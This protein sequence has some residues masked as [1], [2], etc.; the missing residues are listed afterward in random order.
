MTADALTPNMA[1]AREAEAARTLG[2]R[3]EHWARMQPAKP[4]VK[5]A[6]PWLTYG[7]TERRTAEFGAGLQSLGVGKGDR[8]AILSATRV[9]VVLAL[10]GIARSG[11]IAVPLNTFLKGEFLRFQIQ[12]SEPKAIVVDAEGAAELAAVVGE[13]KHRPTVILLDAAKDGD[14]TKKPDPAKVPATLAALEVHGFT[15]LHLDRNRFAPPAITERDPFCIMYTSGTTGMPKGCVLSH[16][17]MMIC[18]VPQLADGW[19]EPDDITYSLFPL[20]HLAGVG[21]G[22][23][24]S[25]QC[26]SSIVIE[27]VFSARAFIARVVEEGAT[28]AFGIGAA[29]KAVLAA[30]ASE[31]DRRHR[32]RLAIFPPMDP[33]AQEAFEARFGVNL[34]CSAYGQ[35]EIT[36]I[37]R[38]NN[39]EARL[40]RGSLGRPSSRID[41][42]LVDDND[43]PVARGEV[44]EIVVRP[45][46]PELIF[47]GYWKRPDATV[48][49]LR[50]LWH[51]TGDLARFDERGI[52]Y[53]V[54]RKRDAIRRR[55]ENVSS[56]ELERAI[57]KHPKIAAV[58]VHGVPSPLG[59]QEIKACIVGAEGTIDSAELFDFFK[60]TLPYF[61][62]PRYVEF[63]E[64]LPVNAN[65]RVT[66]QLLRERGIGT[67]VDLEAAGFVISREQRRG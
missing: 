7:E 42:E 32:L 6:S 22:L 13:L 34:N 12:E 28:V 21:T 23:L 18:P 45:R 17:Y 60:R 9:E 1:R 52:L 2:P 37:A 49:V 16:G 15:A 26:G 57:L 5:C 46:Q 24:G 8:V 10:F 38:L 35:T 47:Q 65:G 20:F 62:V 14:S 58:A 40:A 50:N 63:F 48:A 41:L 3:L 30:P 51:H 11:A 67:A 53:F 64:A 56:V 36:T 39:E 43:Y 33:D 4:F 54:D 44:G 19:T 55:G 31:L 25:L 29:A 66:K 59:E 61:A 27:S